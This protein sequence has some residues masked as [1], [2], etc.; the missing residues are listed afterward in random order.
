M[1]F[2]LHFVR[3][4]LLLLICGATSVFG[5]AALATPAAFTFDPTPA[6][7]LTPGQE[8]GKAVVVIRLVGDPAI[9]PGTISLE[10]RAANDKPGTVVGFEAGP[11]NSQAGSLTW[12]V[13]ATVTSLPTNSSSM[14]YLTARYAGYTQVLP[15]TLSN[16]P[17]GSFSWKVK[18]TVEK[19]RW[20]ASD[21]LRF[22]ISTGPVP[23][24]DVRLLSGSF[25]DS[26]QLNALKT[27]F[28]LCFDQ[29]V[30]CDGAPIVLAANTSYDLVIRAVGETIAPPG[31]YSG[32]FSIVSA[33]K[34]EGDSFPVTL[35]L[36]DSFWKAVGVI[37]I[38]LGVF[39][40]FFVNTWT[41]RRNDRN[42]RLRP[43]AAL[44][45]EAQRLQDAF[46]DLQPRAQ[47]DFAN[48]QAAT[49]D[50]LNT[51]SI[52][53]LKEKG[54]IGSVIP[55]LRGSDAVAEN[56]QKY[57]IFLAELSKRLTVLSL[58][59]RAA[60]QAISLWKKTPTAATRPK[61]QTA[62][63]ALDNLVEPGFVADVQV[64]AAEIEKVLL[65]LRGALNEAQGIAEDANAGPALEIGYSSERIAFETEVLNVVGWLTFGILSL[66][67]GSYLLIAADPGFGQWKDLLLCL[68]W[69]FGVPAAGEKLSTLSSTSV[70][71]GFGLTLTK[72]A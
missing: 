12:F 34:P 8:T 28:Q 21:P 46:T 4:C 38:A 47:T 65:E 10:D 66:A 45:A 69:G 71:Q 33:E 7:N 44:I 64:V 58:L 29:D 70:A 13:T 2:S 36:S 42:A 51:L 5:S 30:S 54:Y 27:S 52:R 48:A 9:L 14:R 59:W 3:G 55:P 62:L 68:L 23:A 1:G 11:P 56:A 63:T 41:Q 15:Y 6:V 25:V 40:S 24:T 16:K 37:L 50:V 17:A 72:V 53:N 57:E 22:S 19:R 49:T 61:L 32:S 43:A 18:P 35:Y 26:D 60:D 39:C 67:V 20:D 31:D